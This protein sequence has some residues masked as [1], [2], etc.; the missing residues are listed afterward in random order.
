MGNIFCIFKIFN[1]NRTSTLLEL[2][3]LK[4]TYIHTYIHKYIHVLLIAD[5]ECIVTVSVVDCG[6]GIS[7]SDQLRLFNDFVQIRPGLLQKGRGSGLG[8]AISKQIVELHKV[9]MYA[10]MYVQYVQFCVHKVY[11]CMYVYV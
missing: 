1:P 11:A 5:N 6:M 9:S 2:H 8:L 10:C 3:S 7:A 4:Y